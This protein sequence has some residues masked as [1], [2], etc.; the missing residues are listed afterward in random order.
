M[1]HYVV[2]LYKMLF[3]ELY[4]QMLTSVVKFTLLAN[5]CRLLHGYVCC[6]S[7]N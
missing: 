3:G 6:L 4:I 2:R 1:I 5:S 7:Y